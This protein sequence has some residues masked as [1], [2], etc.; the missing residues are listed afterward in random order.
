MSGVLF[1]GFCFVTLEFWIEGGEILQTM[2]YPGDAAD[3]KTALQ[4]MAFS[5]KTGE[6]LSEAVY[7]FCREI[8][9][10]ANYSG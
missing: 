7:V 9:A 8:L 1:A 10:G 3:I 4:H 2:L 5:L 6:P